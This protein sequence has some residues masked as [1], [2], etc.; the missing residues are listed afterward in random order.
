MRQLDSP[1]LFKFN[2]PELAQFSGG[3]TIILKQS[4]VDEA[5]FKAPYI[6]ANDEFRRLFSRSPERF[7][8]TLREIDQS[9]DKNW[10]GTINQLRNMVNHPNPDRADAARRILDAIEDFPN[11]TKFGYKKQYGWLL[12]Y[13]EAFGRFTEAE[14]ALA[15][16]D[17]WVKALNDGCEAFENLQAHRA[18]ANANQVKGATALARDALIEAYKAL[19]DR[20]HATLFLHPDENIQALFDHLNEYI[21]KSKSVPKRKKKKDGENGDES[22]KDNE[23]SDSNGTIDHSEDDLDGD[24]VDVSE[25]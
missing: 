16:V 9:N 11:P 13:K 22:E 1:H 10:H 24:Y 5:T 8:T 20:I 4:N 2:N 21:K 23:S 25:D 6:A 3:I 7:G 14:L 17:E 12:K 18:A 15:T 19:T